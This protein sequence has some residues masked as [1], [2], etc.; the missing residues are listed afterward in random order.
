[1]VYL[2]QL[3]HSKGKGRRKE[4]REHFCQSSHDPHEARECFDGF[5]DLSQTD[6]TKRVAK[7]ATR[8]FCC[9]FTVKRR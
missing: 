4:V 8:F 6:S 9:Q 1:M 3:N 7:K 5:G 2:E